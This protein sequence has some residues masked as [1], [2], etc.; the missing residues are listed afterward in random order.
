MMVDAEPAD[1]AVVDK[2]R[3]GNVRLSRYHTQL[4]STERELFLT[5]EW[6]LVYPRIQ[7][8]GLDIHTLAGQIKESDQ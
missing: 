2:M 5:E 1:N 4:Q 8:L 6:P 3:P 7:Q